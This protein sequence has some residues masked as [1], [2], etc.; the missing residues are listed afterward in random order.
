MATFYTNPSFDISLRSAIPRHGEIYN[1]MVLRLHQGANNENP[2]AYDSTHHSL[3]TRH[4]RNHHKSCTLFTPKSYAR[5]TLE[6]AE[7]VFWN[8]SAQ[9]KFADEKANTIIPVYFSE[10]DEQGTKSEKTKKQQSQ[11]IV[12]SLAVKTLSQ[13]KINKGV[14]IIQIIRFFLHFKC[15]QAF[16]HH[17]YLW[18]INFLTYTCSNLTLE[19][20]SL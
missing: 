10:L 2:R 15:F 1:I 11:Q 17:S 20:L 14:S 13:T 8:L 18:E 16:I 9:L 5:S 3:E 7:K 12:F 6:E 19:I 4:T